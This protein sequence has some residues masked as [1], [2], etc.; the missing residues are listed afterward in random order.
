MTYD[1]ARRWLGLYFLIFTAALGGYVLIF[2]ESPML[3]IGREDANA[4][5]QIVVPVL[6]GQLVTA[7]K[8]LSRANSPEDKRIAPIPRWAIVTPPI[9][10]VSLVLL[11]IVGMVVR[12]PEP[13]GW[14][15][16]PGTFKAVLTFA[17]S[18]LNAST[19]FLVSRL[20][21]SDGPPEPAHAAAPANVT[22][23]DG[24]P[25]Q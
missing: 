4:S 1:E 10:V 15:V 16:P 14:G 3:P 23:P 24:A 2:P 12:N 5:F 18:I 6:I 17:I 20:F 9:I 11:A 13:N 19:V 7:F 8:W 22:K 21:P 25:G